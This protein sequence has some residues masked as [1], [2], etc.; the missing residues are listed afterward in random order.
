MS[1][2]WA[3]GHPVTALSF[4]ISLPNMHWGG[5]WG[6]VEGFLQTAGK[7]S[8]KETLG[9]KTKGHLLSINLTQDPWSATSHWTAACLCLGRYWLLPEE[10][11][12]PISQVT[13]AFPGK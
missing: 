2:P 9:I 10:R 11:R 13:L 7:S 5:K 12:S 1:G 6:V 8:Q 3:P 4:S